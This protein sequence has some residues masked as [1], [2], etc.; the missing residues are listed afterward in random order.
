[1]ILVKLEVLVPIKLI[2]QMKQ[3]YGLMTKGKSTNI[4]IYFLSHKGW[5]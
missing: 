1:M 5:V 4:S 2:L 3:M